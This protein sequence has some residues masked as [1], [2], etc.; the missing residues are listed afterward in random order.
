MYKR[1]LSPLSRSALSH[2]A[3]EG[4]RALLDINLGDVSIAPGVD[5][6]DVASRAQGYSGADITNVCRSACMYVHVHFWYAV[7]SAHSEGFPVLPLFKLIT[8]MYMYMLMCTCTRVGEYM[9]TC[10]SNLG[11]PPHFHAVP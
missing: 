11:I 4:R 1:D 10:P 3:A 9:C 2:S 5:L 8:Y 7:R 6:D